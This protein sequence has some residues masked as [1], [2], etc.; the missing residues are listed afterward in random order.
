MKEVWYLSVVLLMLGVLAGFSSVT[1]P[2][3][4][5]A[6]NLPPQWDFPTAEFS[7]DGS[8]LNLDLSDAFFDPDGD[9]LSFSV[10]PSAGVGAGLNGDVLV[11]LA[12]KDGQVTITAS[13]GKMQ[14]SKTIA[15]HKI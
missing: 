3:G 15:V 12:E 10:S 5:F 4:A 8:R 7:T 2:T 14:V 1:T 11:I 13:D 9:P 6:G